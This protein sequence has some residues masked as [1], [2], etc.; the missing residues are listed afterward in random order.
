MIHGVVLYVG[1]Q[2]LIHI[3]TVLLEA[4]ICIFHVL[5]VHCDSMIYFPVVEIMYFPVVLLKCTLSCLWDRDILLP[6]KTV[7]NVQ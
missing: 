3:Y 1:R 4:A 6:F 5:N 7:T 2:G